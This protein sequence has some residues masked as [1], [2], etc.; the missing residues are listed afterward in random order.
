MYYFKALPKAK[1]SL[2]KPKILYETLLS[3][4]ISIGTSQSTGQPNVVTQLQSITTLLFLFFTK[5]N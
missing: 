1:V 5:T 4:V 3:A 2:C